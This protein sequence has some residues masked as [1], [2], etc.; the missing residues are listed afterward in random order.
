[1]YNNQVGGGPGYSLRKKIN[2]TPKAHQTLINSASKRAGRSPSPDPQDFT[3]L[4][5]SQPD[6]GIPQR[7]PDELEDVFSSPAALSARFPHALPTAVRTQYGDSF[8]EFAI[9]D[10]LGPG[11]SETDMQSF[12]VDASITLTP[13]TPSRPLDQAP[14]SH[15]NIF[16]PPVTLTMDQRAQADRALEAF[17]ANNGFSAPNDFG[18]MAHPQALGSGDD[19]GSS[20]P[21][22]F[23]VASGSGGVD[24][25]APADDEDA[26]N[27][28][29]DDKHLQGN[30]PEDEGSG[31]PSSASKPRQ[32]TGRISKENWERL[33]SGFVRIDTLIDQLALETGRTRDNIISLWQN[34]H[35][36]KRALM[37]GWNMYQRY[38]KDNRAQERKR[39]GDP[40]ANCKISNF[41]RLLDR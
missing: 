28:D 12:C 4:P 17:F 14:L 13:D 30:P 3:K 35:S 32:S 20:A 21:N 15:P 39:A 19:T 9:D 8:T 22:D 6:F 34:T 33:R 18:M 16:P 31:S 25:N 41:L 2:T 29:F 23:G 36:F 5:L 27:P 1:M 37:S 38:F 40:T 7:P 11:A 26:S 24:Y 10:L